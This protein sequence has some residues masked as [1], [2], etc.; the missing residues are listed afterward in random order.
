MAVLLPRFFCIP[1]LYTTGIFH[2]LCTIGTVAGST[3]RRLSR[4]I[5]VIPRCA[6][7]LCHYVFSRFSLAQ[8]LSFMLLHV[9]FMDC[10]Y[11]S[12]RRII[13]II[14]F[15]WFIF[16]LSIYSVP[17]ILSAIPLVLLYVLFIW[18]SISLIP[19]LLCS[20]AS[21]ALETESNIGAYHGSFC[22]FSFFVL[23]S[24]SFLPL[25]CS[26][27]ISSQSSEK[28]TCF[29]STSYSYLFN[30]GDA[31]EEAFCPFSSQFILRCLCACLV[32][33]FFLLCPQF[34]TYTA[35]DPR[36][37]S[38]VCVRVLRSCFSLPLFY[39]SAFSA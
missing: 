2:K 24:L 34:C 16:K 20:S 36:S 28:Q 33:F 9:L 25:L 8:F 10:P 14:P 15:H 22:I 17:L 12:S 31:I 1:R 18:K 29:C 7:F 13:G 27:H 19:S 26:F 5:R 37:D 3:S 23:G 30:H 39:I 11:S 38:C 4:T 32:R 21:N 35:V 6:L